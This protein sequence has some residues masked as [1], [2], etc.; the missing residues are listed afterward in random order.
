[1]QYNAPKSM[2]ENYAITMLTNTGVM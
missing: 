1:M 2:L